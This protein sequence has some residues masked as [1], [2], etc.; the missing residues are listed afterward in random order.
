MRRL[1]IL[2][3]LILAGALSLP[4]YAQEQGA[5]VAPEAKESVGSSS[6]ASAA[7]QGSAGSSDG[8]R[9]TW[10]P[11][12]IWFSGF[13][14]TVGAGGRTASVDAG[15][16]DLASHLNFGW[17][18]VLDVGKGRFGVVTDLQY[19]HLEADHSFSSPPPQPFSEAEADSKLFV[20]DPEFYV[21]AVET[22]RGSF[23]V[24]A[25]IRYW[26][27]DNDIK[28]LPGLLPGVT[29][30]GGDDWVDPIVGFRFRVNL[31]QEKKWFIPAKADIGGFDA[32]ADLTWQ[33]FGGI[34][35]KVTLF[36]RSSAIIVG[37]RKIFVDR[38]SDGK[39]LKV[40]LS[41]PIFGTTMSFGQ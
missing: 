2:A 33:V 18:T 37:Y 20:L 1:A 11:S 26:H 24:L 34:G 31:D 22:D 38:E 3:A 19:L 41:G 6:S 14:G 39:L 21:R 17:S 13:S 5:A 12:Y 27:L 29:V 8:W 25:G 4:T 40:N 28:F 9:V 16:W 23:D 35:R 10:A 32:G 36:G 30:N 7:S 15:F